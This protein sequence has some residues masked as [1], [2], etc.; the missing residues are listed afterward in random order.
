MILPEGVPVLE[1]EN[2]ILRN[3]S[4]ADSPELFTMRKD[5]RMHAYTDTKPDQTI[6][7]TE[8]Y[9]EKMLKG[10]E[11][12]QWLIWVIVHQKLNRLI[13]SIS[14]WNLDAL[15]GTAELGYAITPDHQGRGF[16]KEALLRVAEYAFRTLRLL[17]LEAYSE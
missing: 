13:G 10:V 17:A 3:L 14:L 12:R 5:P 8:A 4:L 1:T 9:I 2:L 7:E 16:M 11:E 15:Q 6:E